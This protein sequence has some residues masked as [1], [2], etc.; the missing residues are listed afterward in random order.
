MVVR[1]TKEYHKN[2]L[3]NT[4]GEHF[5]AYHFFV[6]GLTGNVDNS[7]LEVNCESNYC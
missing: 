2:D 3:N 1:Q 7:V 6:G 4:S 5:N